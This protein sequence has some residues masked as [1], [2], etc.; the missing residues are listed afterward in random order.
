MPRDAIPPEFT[1]HVPEVLFTWAEGQLNKNLRSAKRGAAPGPSGM[2]VEHLHPL[3]D[4]SGDLRLFAAAA[5]MCARGQVPE[6]IQTAVKL[7]RM[8]ALSKAMV[9]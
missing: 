9:A 1:R 7:G 8:I 6:S 5:E 4:H 3:F 2:T